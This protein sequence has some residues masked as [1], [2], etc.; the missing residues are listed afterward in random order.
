MVFWDWAGPR[1]GGEGIHPGEE[2]LC[3]LRVQEPGSWLGLWLTSR[4]RSSI[5]KVQG[6]TSQWRERPLPGSNAI[7]DPSL[8]EPVL[9]WAGFLRWFF[10]PS[11]MIESERA[12]LLSQWY[13]KGG[14]FHVAQLMGD[15]RSRGKNLGLALVNCIASWGQGSKR[16][17]VQLKYAVIEQ[18]HAV[19]DNENV[20]SYSVI[21]KRMVSLGLPAT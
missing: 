8:C 9:A 12:S 18:T 21:M 4:A 13:L 15:L 2:Q 16:E 11:F 17:R 5:C 3:W 10:L 20:L 14:W 1:D 19:G 7:C 6:W